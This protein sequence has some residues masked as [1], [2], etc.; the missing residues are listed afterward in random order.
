MGENMRIAVIIPYFQREPGIL[1]KAVQSALNQRG[2]IRPYIIVVDD[3]SP[4]PAASELAGLLPE[5]REDIMVIEQ[6]NAGP[7][8]ARN[9]G[10]DA[11]PDEIELV[12]FLDSDDEWAPD[13]LQNAMEALHAGCDFFFADHWDYSGET[14]RFGRSRE[15]GTF[16]PH[17]HPLIR[18]D[19][20]LHWFSGDFVDQLIREYVIGAPT[21]VVRRS[22]L[23]Q[24]RFPTRFRK[25][26][27]DH[28][29]WLKIAASGA[30][31]AFSERVE[32][33]MGKGVNI[34]DGSG[35]GTEGALERIVDY[36]GLLAT[37]R[38]EYA[39]TEAQKDLLS[40]RLAQSRREFVRVFVHDIVRGRLKSARYAWRQLRYDP[41][42]MA[43]FFPELTRIVLERIQPVS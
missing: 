11:I 40:R 2:V 9:T 37:M 42:T 15:R 25:A 38:L 31:V 22:F 24:H 32:C 10:I 17:D 13:H 43:I 33:R 16:R 12:A 26:G 41:L 23:D 3:S 21:V 28:L 30:K 29:L 8:G 14:T 5:Y 4:V 1:R 34:Y 36:C 20:P 27:E 35:W 39:K 18:I 6:P 7:G 19:S